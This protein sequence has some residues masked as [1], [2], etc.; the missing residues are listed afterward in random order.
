MSR[1]CPG[2]RAI[3][4][5]RRLAKPGRVVACPSVCRLYISAPVCTKSSWR[6]A[7]IAPAVCWHVSRGRTRTFVWNGLRAHGNAADG[8]R[9]RFSFPF[10]LLME[11]CLHAGPSGKDKPMSLAMASHTACRTVRE[12]LSRRTPGP[13]AGLLRSCGRDQH[14]R[15]HHHHPRPPVAGAA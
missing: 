3:S 8:R 11:A 4:H 14:D 15:N 2:G 13:L 7:A 12:T 10:F 5:T 6:Q 9:G 1:C